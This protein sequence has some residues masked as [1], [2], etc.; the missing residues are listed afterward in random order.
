VKIDGAFIRE[1]QSDASNR[2]FVAAMIDIAHSLG[3]SVIAEHVED[4][5][6]LAILRGLGVDMVQGFHLGRPAAQL[7][8]G[9][10]H[11]QVVAPPRQAAP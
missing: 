2:L 9:R 7:A 11:L 8:D 6:T 10:G 4:A 1:L 3:K 5:A